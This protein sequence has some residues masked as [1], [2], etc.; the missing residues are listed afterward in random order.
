[1]DRFQKSKLNSSWSTITEDRGPR[2]VMVIYHRGSDLECIWFILF[3]VAGVSWDAFSHLSCPQSPELPHCL[4]IQNPKHQ[5]GR[6]L[7]CS[8]PRTSLSFGKWGNWGPER[9][10]R[11]QHHWWEEGLTSGFLISRPVF[12]FLTHCPMSLSWCCGVC[13]ALGPL[14]NPVIGSTILLTTWKTESIALSI[15]SRGNWGPGAARPH[16]KPMPEQDTNLAFRIPCLGS[17]LLLPAPTSSAHSGVTTPVRDR[18]YLTQTTLPGATCCV[19][20][21]NRT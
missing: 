13:S 2:R 20:Q 21:K 5:N 12:S 10:P 16:G 18:C 7:E 17:S 8:H 4:A 15:T 1:M 14:Q 9:G 3:R 11:P 6:A 19:L